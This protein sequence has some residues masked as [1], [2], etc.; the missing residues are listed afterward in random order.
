M[1][2]KPFVMSFRKDVV[3]RKAFSPS[4]SLQSLVFT[5]KGRSLTRAI[6]C[7]ELVVR[8]LS[9][10]ERMFGHFNVEPP[11]CDM[12][13]LRVSNTERFVT[14][15]NFAKHCYTY[16]RAALCCLELLES[17]FSCW[18]VCPQLYHLQNNNM[19]IYI[20]PVSAR[21]WRCVK[22]SNTFYTA[23]NT[24]AITLRKRRKDVTFYNLLHPVASFSFLF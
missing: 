12:A 18:M 21:F 15:S 13:F 14:A 24:I 1:W 2:P 8:F 22:S 6:H 3:Y 4:W 19:V 9:R 5:D 10:W 20:A 23:I 11:L 16:S 17:P 7:W